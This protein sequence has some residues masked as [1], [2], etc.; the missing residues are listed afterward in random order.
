MAS[1]SF[2]VF[3]L[4]SIVCHHGRYNHDTR[5]EARGDASGPKIDNGNIDT[6]RLLLEVTFNRH[7][8]LTPLVFGGKSDHINGYVGRQWWAV[9]WM[10]N[11]RGMLF[12]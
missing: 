2:Y 9:E 12:G 10:R 3:V 5:G 8:G 6:G 1:Q 11:Q 7:P 4:Q